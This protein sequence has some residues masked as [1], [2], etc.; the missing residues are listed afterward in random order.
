MKQC[1]PARWPPLGRCLA[2]Q[3]AT[4]RQSSQTRGVTEQQRTQRGTFQAGTRLGGPTK[5]VT[6]G[7]TRESQPLPVT[8]EPARYYAQ[9]ITP[10]VTSRNAPLG[11][12]RR[13]VEATQRYVATHGLQ[14]LLGEL[15]HNASYQTHWSAWPYS[16]FFFAASRK[17]G[18][19]P[20]PWSKIP[21]PLMYRARGEARKRQTSPTSRG[22]PRRPS[23]TVAATAAIPASFP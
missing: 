4:L 18:F 8:G 14:V 19:S 21:A 11:D 23:G 15:V 12:A 10:L 6:E 17:A 16:L 9:S 22:S 5:H 2:D 1:I 7:W 3:V 13:F 20:P